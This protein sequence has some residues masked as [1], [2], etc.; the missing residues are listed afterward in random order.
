MYTPTPI[1]NPGPRE[2]DLLRLLSNVRAKEGHAAHLTLID[3]THAELRA[4]PQG[5]R[6]VRMFR[7]AGHYFAGGDWINQGDALRWARD[8]D[9][10][11]GKPF[12]VHTV[13]G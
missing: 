1:H 3:G 5:S 4:F 13:E 8:K 12:N 10:S 9:A 2:A 6:V 7:I 11:D